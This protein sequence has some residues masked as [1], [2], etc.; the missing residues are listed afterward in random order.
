MKKF[1]EKRKPAGNYSIMVVASGK[2]GVRRYEVSR[3][4]LKIGVAGAA[5]FC[6]AFVAVLGALVVYRNSYV[7][8]CN[9]KTNAAQFVAERAD[10]I[11]RINSLED[12]LAR[13]DRFASKVGATMG[14]SS[15]S[16][17]SHLTGQGPVDEEVWL[18]V[19]ERS[20]ASP[21]TIRLGENRW[22]SPFYG[23]LGEG[24]GFSLDKLSQKMLGVE[25]RVHS[26]FAREKDRMYFWS[27]LPTLWP[28]KG[29]ITSEFGDRR[30]WGGRGRIHEGIDIAA[31]R[32]TPIIAP[33][34]GTVTYVGYR[35]GYGKT[36]ILD[37]GYGITTLYGHCQSMHVEE[38]QTVKR[39]MLIASIGNT[40]R[41]TGPHLHYEVRVDDVAVNPML[42]VMSD[43]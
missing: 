1:D 16:G 25:E 42:Y 18:P 3:W 13:V 10:L 20:L 4:I 15:S 2:A 38:G 23:S 41:S 12:S 21:P 39:G 19:L 5:V 9:V 43:L 29:W 35:R 11:E 26:V 27:S 37:H 22:K 30:G 33:G 31:P 40:G 24:L 32:G 36:V 17:L 6:V 14:S 34:S 28:A 7:A 8:T